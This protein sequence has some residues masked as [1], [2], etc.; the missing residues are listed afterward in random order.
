M[1]QLPVMPAQAGIRFFFGFCS[2][3]FPGPRI[4][5]GAPFT[6]LSI[7]SMSR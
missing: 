7:L 6:P 2:L 4:E 3:F 5:S 1:T